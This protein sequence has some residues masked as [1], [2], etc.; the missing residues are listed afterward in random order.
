MEVTE[1]VQ[2]PLQN[3]AWLFE[4]DTIERVTS[5]TT[6]V[7]TDGHDKPRNNQ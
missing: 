6:C 4:V 5:P 2:N 1:G 7:D 3:D